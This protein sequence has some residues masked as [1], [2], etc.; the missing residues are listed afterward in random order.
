MVFQFHQRL[1][2]VGDECNPNL[3]MYIIFTFTVKGFNL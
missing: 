2:A 3:V 1:Q